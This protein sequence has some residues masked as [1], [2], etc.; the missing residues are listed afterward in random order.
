M[1]NYSPL[2]SPLS[3]KA[4]GSILLSFKKVRTIYQPMCIYIYVDFITDSLAETRH[5]EIRVK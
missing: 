2:F 4:I 3:L 5:N 1:Q